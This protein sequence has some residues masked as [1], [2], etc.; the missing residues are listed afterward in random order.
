MASL[1]PPHAATQ[2]PLPA[3][4]WN[5]TIFEGL[6]TPSLIQTPS[7]VAWI[8]PS[9]QHPAP[10][11][12]H[13]IVTMDTAPRRRPNPWSGFH[14]R[15]PG[16]TELNYLPE[17]RYD[18]RDDAA[19]RVLVEWRAIT[20]ELDSGNGAVNSFL[21]CQEPNCPHKK[22][23]FEKFPSFKEHLIWHAQQKVI[24]EQGGMGNTQNY[25]RRLAAATKEGKALARGPFYKTMTDRYHS[26]AAF[27]EA[28]RA[29]R[30]GE[31]HT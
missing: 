9:M 16:S 21:W 13:L 24:K 5:A 23:F 17:D 10:P 28:A 12:Q 14:E 4:S 6:P 26:L 18:C 3:P 31:L 19:V 8:Y 7:S 29:R 22:Y 25:K 30:R 27:V 15:L 11:S 20:Q 2:I 1:F